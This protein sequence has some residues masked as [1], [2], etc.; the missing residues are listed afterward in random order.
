LGELLLENI[1]K[2]AGSEV[3]RVVK[4]QAENLTASGKLMPIRD[5]AR[6]LGISKS[7]AARKI[8]RAKSVVTKWL[9]KRRKFF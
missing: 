9:R 3:Y 7:D 8:E 2:E 6:D 1:E 5:L 4:Y